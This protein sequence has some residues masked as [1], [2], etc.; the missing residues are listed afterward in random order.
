MSDDLHVEVSTLAPP[1]E[2]HYR[3]AYALK[4]LR[5]YLIP[6]ANDEISQEQLRELESYGGGEVTEHGDSKLNTSQVNF[7][8]TLKL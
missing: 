6:D 5:R 4:E 2:A 8:G 7:R 1:S 3:M